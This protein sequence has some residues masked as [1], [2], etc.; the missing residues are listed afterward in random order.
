MPL[1]KLCHAQRS[2]REAGC[3]TFLV[4]FTALINVITMAYLM[5]TQE[6]T[7]TSHL[8]Y[9]FFTTS[10]R[11]CMTR[12]AVQTIMDTN[13][14][15]PIVLL[16]QS[17]TRLSVSWQGVH[18]I[19]VSPRRSQELGAAARE[20]LLR[21]NYRRV[22][23]LDSSLMVLRSLDHLFRIDPGS[24]VASP[25]AYWLPHAP[26]SAAGPLVFNSQ[27]LASGVS[28]DDALARRAES[29][30]SSLPWQSH[31]PLDP[32]L[33]VLFEEYLPGEALYD[34]SN[35]AR[36]DLYVIQ[37]RGRWNPQEWSF[38]SFVSAHSNATDALK[39][40][41]NWWD[42]EERVCRGQQWRLGPLARNTR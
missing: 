29:I 19:V 34:Y 9:V 32:R 7:V 22:V 3:T 26:L 14:R 21:F 2:M 11:E 27:L 30:V 31:T 15:V 33:L 16:T 35:T 10:K 13:T 41:Q 1:E 5:P 28:L 38:D 17:Q 37:F 12:V 24:G 39:L 42:C 18:H 23:F 4:C 40:L 6:Q 20:S 8:A 36:D 25:S